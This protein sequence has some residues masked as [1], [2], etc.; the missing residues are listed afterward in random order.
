MALSW[1]ARPGVVE[2]QLERRRRFLDAELAREQATLR[3][4]RRE[5]GHPF[6]EAVWMVTLTIQQFRVELRWLRKVAEELG[7]RAPPQ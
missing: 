5:V 1:R 6:H 3:A 7:R 2:R 4:I